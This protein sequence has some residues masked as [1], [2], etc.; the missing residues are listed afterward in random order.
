MKA[1]RFNVVNNDVEKLNELL[2]HY[3]IRANNFKL[4]DNLKFGLPHLARDG[5][6]L[7]PAGKAALSSCWVDVILTALGLRR[8]ALPLR[9]SYKTIVQA[10]WDKSPHR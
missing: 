6:H 9:I 10:T 2:V 8:K 7:N 1:D 3:S 4:F 5:L